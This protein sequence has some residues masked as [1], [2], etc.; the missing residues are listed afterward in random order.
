MV[1][2]KWLFRILTNGKHVVNPLAL[3][4]EDAANTSL[5]TPRASRVLENTARKEGK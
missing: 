3:G 2:R 5:H 1:N 4:E